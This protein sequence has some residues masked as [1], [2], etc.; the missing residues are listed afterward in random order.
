MA[1]DFA[2]VNEAVFHPFLELRLADRKKFAGPFEI[3]VSSELVD[4]AI[5][6]V[7]PAGLRAGTDEGCGAD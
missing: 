6:G 4:P 1:G 7:A 3:H 5:H 2:R